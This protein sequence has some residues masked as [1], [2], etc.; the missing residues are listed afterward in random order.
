[1]VVALKVIC[2]SISLPQ[3]YVSRLAIKEKQTMLNLSSYNSNSVAL[4]V[5]AIVNSSISVV[6]NAGEL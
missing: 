6:A 3:W 5:A 1:M 2:E 4:S